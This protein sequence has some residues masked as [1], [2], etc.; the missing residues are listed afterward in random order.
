MMRR[1]ASAL[2]RSGRLSSRMTI[3]GRSVVAA[4]SPLQRYR[5]RRRSDR[6][7]AAR[8][9]SA[10][11]HGPPGGR[12]RS[13]LAWLKFSYPCLSASVQVQKSRKTKRLRPVG[14]SQSTLVRRRSFVL[15]V[16]LSDGFAEC[17]DGASQFATQ[18]ANAAYTEQDDD[19]YQDDEEFSR[20]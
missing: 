3:S 20:A 5:L 17:A 11:L 9:G 8:R 12:P 16:C 6:C 15:V 18:P 1:Q 14:D 13:V 7:R 4:G 19:D 2:E 10:A